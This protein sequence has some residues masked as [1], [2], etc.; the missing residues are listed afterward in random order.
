MR[1]GWMMAAR[2]RAAGRGHRARV[3][4]LW[5]SRRGVASV[6]AMIF[7]VMFGALSVA[8]AVA[9]Q[10]NLR[11]AATHMHITRAMSAAETGMA[12]AQKR[13]ADS[14]SRFSVSK[15]V[16]SSDMGWRL[17]TGNTT[18]ADGIIN[19]LPARDGRADTMQ[20]RGV[21]DALVSSHQK[22]VNII[23]ASGFPTSASV[24]GP[25]GTVDTTVYKNSTWVRTPLLAIDEDASRAGVRAAGYQITYA[26]LANGTDVRI[27]VTG[28]SS[29]GTSGSGYGYRG[30]AGAT[31]TRP[32]TRVIQQDFRIRKQPK[33]AVLAPSRIMIGKNVI[34][35]GSLG[36]R[37]TDVTRPNGDPV[38]TKGDFD[39]LD[40]TL[41]AKLARFR[42]ALA[43]YDVD[44]DN[45]LRV[46]HPI[47]SQG[48]PGTAELNAKGWS[49]NAFADVT[50]DGYVDEFDI[51]INHYD[52]NRDGDVV[53][54]ARL[55][56]G[57]PN[58]G[59]TPEFTADEDLAFL[60]D[61]ANADRNA[62]GISGF[63][64]A[65]DNG[66]ISAA[67]AMLDP[68]DRA[69]G[70]RDGVINWKDQYSKVRGQMLFKTTSSAWA[71][72]RGGSY[73]SQLQGPFI[74]PDRQSSTVFG[75]SDTDLPAID[76]S[77]FT[78]AQSPLTAAADG[79]SFNQQVAS[80][81]GISTSQLATYTEAGASATAPKYW[82]GD[83]DD[84]Y[85]FSRTGRHLYEKMPFNSP[86]YSDYYYRPR[87]ENMTFK[88][89]QIPQGNNGLFINCTFVGV[90]FV[91]SYQDNTHTNWSLYGQLIWSTSQNK[92]VPNTQ[93]LDK[94]DFLRYTTGNVVD[95]PANYSSFPDP[96]VIQGQ[97]LVGTSRDT[98][99]FSNNIRFHDCLFVGSIVSDTPTSYTNLRNKLQFTGSTRFTTEHPTQPNNANLNP[100]PSAKP[101]IAKS[102]MMLPNYSVDIGSFNAPTD[103]FSGGPTAQ[104][105]QLRGSVVAGVLD[106]RGTA[107]I[108]GALFLTFAPVA[109]QGPLLQNGQTVGNPANFNT[110]LGYFGPTDGDGESIDPRNLPIVGGRRIVG[111]DTDGDGIADTGPNDPQPNGST[112]VPFYGYGRVE[113]NWNPNLPMPDGI[114]LPLSTVV[115]TN[116]YREGAQ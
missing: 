68:G 23:N 105:I 5:R 48:L 66:R 39:G 40:A 8:M 94:S 96:P 76:Q 116:T 113:L 53:L 84:A 34:V 12:I 110:T 14:V 106:I 30:T 95:G 43:Q 103:T 114:I 32:V 13:L 35:N 112:P 90:T 74:N 78:A 55:T 100:D 92:P 54:S 37:Y 21:A 101:E 51:F 49:A 72:A 88:N 91:R 50:R 57:T 97:T 77:T 85:V 19:V 16:V 6:L 83:L 44:G 38:Q 26:P 28:Y 62:N 109:G 46:G 67:S 7:L 15:G 65:N 2:V 29:I 10:G 82:R 36:A 20:I 3:R 115:L 9:S 73:A 25:S 70:W 41:D 31:T 104:N 42:Q 45:R 69:L 27:I 86:S 99:R 102:S 63:A 47:E 98:K 79:A 33:H 64:D 61:N 107:S 71:S 59:R 87:Y 93:P 58:A 108:D 56:A 1:A 80:Q 24:F 22:D 81:L 11:T 52:T 89:V 4:G 17:W 60:V 111:Y 18:V 75:V